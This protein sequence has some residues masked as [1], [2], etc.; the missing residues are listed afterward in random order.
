MAGLCALGLLLAGVNNLITIPSVV[1]YCHISKQQAQKGKDIDDPL[2]KEQI[3]K[4]RLLSGPG[5]QVHYLAT[6]KIPTAET[7]YAD[8]SHTTLR[9]DASQPQSHVR[10]ISFRRTA[11]FIAMSGLR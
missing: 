7:K 2:Q 3:Q 9:V 4:R 8:L 6:D 11:P 1:I 5:E 10:L